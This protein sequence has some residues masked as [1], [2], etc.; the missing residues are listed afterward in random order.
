MTQQTAIDAMHEDIARLRARS[1][2]QIEDIRVLRGALAGILNEWHE[3]GADWFT[4]TPG[5][6]EWYAA[7]GLREALN[8]AYGV[9][10][11]LEIRDR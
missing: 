2:A 3:D 6:G 7:P 4:R 5:G 11:G 8:F 10:A 9:M 1:A